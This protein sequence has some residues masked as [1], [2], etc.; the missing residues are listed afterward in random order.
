MDTTAHISTPAPAVPDTLLLTLEEVA[1][2]LRCAPRGVERQ[3]ASPR[4]STARDGSDQQWAH[5]PDGSGWAAHETEAA[6]DARARCA[7]FSEL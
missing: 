6:R 3:I 1:R 4:A 5:I 7:R 2:E